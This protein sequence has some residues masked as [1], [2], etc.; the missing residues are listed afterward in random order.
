MRSENWLAK[1][2]KTVY[3]AREATSF[4]LDDLMKNP[5]AGGVW[6]AEWYAYDQARATEDAAFE[7]LLTRGPTTAAGM[8]VTIAHL[9]SLDDGRL[10]Q[11]MRQLLSLLLKSGVL[12]R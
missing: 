5:E 7:E 9:I 10:S 6:D 4:A 2:H 8:R 1:R 12:A 11:K 3:K